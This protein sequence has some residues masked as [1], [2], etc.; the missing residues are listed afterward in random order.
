[1]SHRKNIMRS[2]KK[3]Q[4]IMKIINEL[5]IGRNH[6]RNHLGIITSRREK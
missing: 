4:I 6:H 5:T 1:M 2:H 3:S